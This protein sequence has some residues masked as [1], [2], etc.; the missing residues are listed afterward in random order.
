MTE[1]SSASGPAHSTVDL[2]VDAGESFGNW[3]LGND[4]EIFP[5]LSSANLACGFHAGDPLTMKRTIGLAKR[6]GVRV[7]AHPGLRD[8]VGFGRRELAASPDEVYADVL[9]QLGALAGMLRAEQLR[10]HHVSPHGALGWMTWRFEPIARAVLQAAR[11]FDPS[12]ALVVL[13]GTVIEEVAR[14]EDVRTVLLGFPERGYLANGQLA[15]RS[16]AGAVITDPDQAAERAVG[17]V[18]DGEVRT[19]D[20]ER[21]Q[22]R[23]DSLLIH[24]DN[25]EAPRI[26]RKVHEALLAAGVTVQAF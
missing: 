15:P 22:V 25:P 19:V 3:R 5:F 14:Q 13:G 1:A 20:G 9:Y 8:L 12:L 10:L 17:M 6:H 18:T 16:T 4:E 23:V 21:L 24:G 26:A 11:D 2:N 7:G